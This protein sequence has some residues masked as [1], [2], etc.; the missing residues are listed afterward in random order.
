MDGMTC[1]SPVV[2]YAEHG[3]KTVTLLNIVVYFT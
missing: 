3:T 1:I 2:K